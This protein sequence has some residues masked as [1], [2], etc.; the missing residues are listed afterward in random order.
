VTGR[1]LANSMKHGDFVSMIALFG[2]GRHTDRLNS[3]FKPLTYGEIDAEAANYNNYV[4]QFDPH[5]S[6][7]TIVTFLVVKDDDNTDLTNFD[8]WYDR[9]E[10]ERYWPY[11]LYRVHLKEN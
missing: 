11:T 1:E 10:G 9:D 8:H 4:A 5:R 2:W 7:E 3:D 6:P